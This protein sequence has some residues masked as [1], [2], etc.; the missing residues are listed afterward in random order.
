MGLSKQRRVT[1]NKGM[2]KEDHVASPLSAEALAMRA[3][4]WDAHDRRWQNLCLKSDAKELIQAI[5]YEVYSKETYG[6]IKDTKDLSTLFATISFEYVSRSDNV[7]A[8]ALAKAA[9]ENFTIVVP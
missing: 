7:L 5:K 9:L 2:Q 6:T 4:L 1:T 8:D 3:A